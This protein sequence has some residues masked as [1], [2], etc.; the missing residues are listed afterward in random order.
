MNKY[1]E[2]IYE[3]AEQE[4]SNRRTKAEAVREQ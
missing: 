2:T 3:L 4:L 1:N